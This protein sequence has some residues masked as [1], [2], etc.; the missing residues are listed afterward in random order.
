MI[1]QSIHHED[2]VFSIRADRK[3]LLLIVKRKHIRD[4]MELIYLVN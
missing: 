4:F 3:S 1:D 2:I